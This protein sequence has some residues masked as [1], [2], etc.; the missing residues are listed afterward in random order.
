M[1]PL[2]ELLNDCNETPWVWWQ[3]VSSAPLLQVNE[4]SASQQR[5]GVAR[6]DIIIISCCEPAPNN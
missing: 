6:L 4:V 2:T 5:S 1:L 3:A